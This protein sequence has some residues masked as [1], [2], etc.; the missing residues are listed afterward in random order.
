MSLILKVFFLHSIFGFCLLLSEHG[1]KDREDD[2]GK[3]GRG[4]D[5]SDDDGGE[6][7]LDF[8]PYSRG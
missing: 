1:V 5:A 7:S 6:R 3:D 8:G 2:E 4:D